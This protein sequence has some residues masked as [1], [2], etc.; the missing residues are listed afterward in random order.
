M[1]WRLLSVFVCVLSLS[2]C[3]GMIETRIVSSG[4]GI[5]APGAILRE[6]APQPAIAAQARLL[7]AQQ[8]EQRGYTQSETGAL[9]LHVAFAE[10]DAAIAVRTKSGDAV[11]DIAAAK[12]KKPL[13]NCADREM[14]LTIT[15]TRIADG[16]ELYRGSAAEY[17]CKAQASDVVPVLISAALDDLRQPKGAYSVRRQGL[18]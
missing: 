16:A 10:R 4:A 1:L 15:L 14:R 2:A 12:R 3:G 6:E 5:T 13:Q 17:H 18:E 7:A 11:R 8:L 9:H